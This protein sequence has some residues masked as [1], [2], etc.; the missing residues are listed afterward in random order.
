L[1]F[2]I[3]LRNLKESIAGFYTCEVSNGYEILTS[4]GFVR[5]KNPGIE[6]FYW[7]LYLDFWLLYRYQSN[8]FQWWFVSN[9]IFLFFNWKKKKKI[10]FRLPS[11]EFQPEII[12]NN[13][14]SIDKLKCEIYTG[15]ICRKILSSKY[16]SVTNLDQNEIEQNLIDNMKYLSN[17][18]QEF[19]LPMICLF[20]YPICD[21]NQI[22]IRSI[23]RKSCYYFQNNSCMKG[24]SHSHHIPTCENLPPSSD[25]ISCM[26]INQY[27]NGKS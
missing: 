11:I 1:I 5:V 7:S 14:Q 16:I 24:F 17:K 6:Y 8:W 20:V 21:N 25:D 3:R 9:W 23:C 10:D 22:N 18:C 19:L 26:K 2:S 15:N 12:S 4:T 13:E 27:R